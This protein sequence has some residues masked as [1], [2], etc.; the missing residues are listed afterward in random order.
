M[1]WVS[2][3]TKENFIVVILEDNRNTDEGK[4]QLNN[5]VAR[6]TGSRQARGDWDYEPKTPA[7]VPI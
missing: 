5:S 1:Q 7:F 3:L 2:D 6:A 4:C